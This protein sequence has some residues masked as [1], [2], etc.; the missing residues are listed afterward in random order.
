MTRLT[1]IC[2]PDGSRYLRRIPTPKLE[3]PDF[4]AA[5]DQHTLFYDVF[6]DEEPGLITLIGP[7]LRTQRRFFSRASFKVDG[8]KAEDVAVD[9]VSPRTGEVTFK[10]PSDDPK[11]LRLSH[12]LPPRMNVQVPI[13]RSNHTKF[14]GKNA[15]VAISKNNDLAWIKDWLRYYVAQHGTNA[16]VLFDNGSDAYDMRALRQAVISVKGI[17]AA[18]VLSAPFPFGPKGV[19]RRAI[20][21]KFFHLSMLH[22]ANRRFLAK[23][24]GVLSVDIDELV[25]HPAGQSV[26][27]AVKSTPRGFLSIPGHW[28]YAKRPC[29]TAG[30]IRHRDHV[31]KRVGGD[32]GM[33]PKWCLDPTGPLAGVYWRVHGVLGEDRYFDH[34]FQY[35]HCRQITTNWDYDRDFEPEDRF[36]TAPEAPLLSEV[37]A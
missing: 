6:Y 1:S 5:F 15:L 3:D 20:N 22:I 19:D 26:Y 17:E 18:E 9:L 23:A 8:I 32:R 2:L 24:N 25:T 33:Q 12:R 4:V 13:N 35:L 27:E 7:S 30:P 10:S 36:E 37:F 16:V 11:T 28:R 29:E 21:A 14:Q 31:L 34:D